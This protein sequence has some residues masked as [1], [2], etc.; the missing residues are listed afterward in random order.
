MNVYK[1][2]YKLINTDN[3]DITKFI[4]L[5]NPFSFNK[6]NPILIGGANNDDDDEDDEWGTLKFYTKLF[7]KILVWVI[8]FCF[9]GPLG[10]W[11]IFTWYTFKRLFL[12]YKIYFRQY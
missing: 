9:F 12:G 3:M 1:N 6:Y 11:V 10:P 8:F 7:L 5:F 4:S 2:Y